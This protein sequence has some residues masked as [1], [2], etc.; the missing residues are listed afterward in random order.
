MKLELIVKEKMMGKSIVMLFIVWIVGKLKLLIGW[1][2]TNSW[3]P[4]GPEA[5]AHSFDWTLR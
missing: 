3:A 5:C 1:K 4:V 2:W